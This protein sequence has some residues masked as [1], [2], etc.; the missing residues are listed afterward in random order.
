MEG[1]LATLEDRLIDFHDI[2]WRGYHKSEEDLIQLFYFKFQDTPILA[3]MDAI[4]EYFIDEIETNMG[5]DLKED[6]HIYF[7][8]L[9]D[10]M[11]QTKDLYII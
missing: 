7:D 10:K 1:F 3:R 5:R 2:E 8:E 11:Y 9:F 6:E 4:K